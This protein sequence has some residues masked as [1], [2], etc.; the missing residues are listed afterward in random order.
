[1]KK[2]FLLLVLML[3]M[4]A[5][6]NVKADDGGFYYI[7]ENSGANLVFCDIEEGDV[8]IPSELIH[9]GKIYPVTT[10][11]GAFQDHYSLTSITIPS[12][13]TTIQAD[14]FSNCM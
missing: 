6:I 8:V 4:G 13:V 11:S 9:N 2:N 3:L 12:S 7:I 1:M 14:A 5:Q 10:I